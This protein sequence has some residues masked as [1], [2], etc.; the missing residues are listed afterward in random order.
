M[1]KKQGFLTSIAETSENV[2]L[3]VSLSGYLFPFLV[4]IYIQYF[5]DVV[6]NKLQTININYSKSEEDQK[7]KKRVYQVKVL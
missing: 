3:F 7:L 4:C 2:Y 5:F 6:R 1:K